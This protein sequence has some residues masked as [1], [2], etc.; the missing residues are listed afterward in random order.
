MKNSGDLFNTVI[1]IPVA[2]VFVLCVLFNSCAPRYGCYFSQTDMPQ[3][4]TAL[5]ADV[6]TV[7]SSQ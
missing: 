7:V 1:R 2:C 3:I 6:C 4:E 5:Q